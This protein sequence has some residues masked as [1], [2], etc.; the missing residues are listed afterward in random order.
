M[1]LLEQVKT[2]TAEI[3]ENENMRRG[4]ELEPEARLLYEKLTGIHMEPVCVVH[5]LYPWMRASLDG[6]SK[7]QTII[8]EVKCP[9]SLKVHYLAL[10]NQVPHYY[11]GQVQHQLAVTDTAETVHYFSYYPSLPGPDSFA[12][13][14]VYRD[15]EYIK[16]MIE[17]ERK[18]YERVYNSTPIN[19]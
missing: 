15:E 12:L 19:N 2:G 10:N 4:K 1:E 14:K 18:W 13:V 5:E 16:E 8:L 11:K 6:L 3:V 7:D 17:E 9:R